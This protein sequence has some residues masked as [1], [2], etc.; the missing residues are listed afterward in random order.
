MSTPP[1]KRLKSSN[2]VDTCIVHCEGLKYGELALCS[3]IREPQDRLSRLQDI[4]MRRLN[5]KAGSVHRMEATCD[6][7]PD[8]LQPH[9]GYHQV[10][11]KNFTMNLG[12]LADV[13]G[14]APAA[15]TSR[16]TRSSSSDHIIF[17]PDCIFCNS[18]KLKKVKA[19]GG[20]W[21]TEGL[22]IFDRGG[23]GKILEMAE[24][25]QDEKLLRRIRGQDLFA[26]EAKWH[27]SCRV[28]YMQ[29]PAKWRSQSKI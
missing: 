2:E 28:A 11:Y 1:S 4:C 9:H 13:H 22:S 24:E 25:K 29:D 19:G 17:A 12:R 6:L 16:S 23:W 21:T 10:C 18:D 20:S 7:I 3:D 14:E 5:Q 26:C 27:R 8:V 15:S